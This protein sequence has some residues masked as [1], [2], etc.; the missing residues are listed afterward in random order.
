MERQTLVQR[1]ALP[2]DEIEPLSMARL[3]VRLEGLDGLGAAERELVLRLVYAVGD[4]AIAA[5]VRI[6]PEAITAAV[7]ALQDGRPVVTDVKMVRAG[8]DRRRAAR[9]GCRVAC[10]ID[11]PEVAER[12]RLSNLPR[13]VEAMR[14]LAPA[15]DGGVVAVGNA[16]TAL[17]AVLDLVDA[18]IARPA[19]I[20]GM[21]VGF[22]AAAEA[23][24]EL[25][26]R[27]VPYITVE[28][29]RGG[30]PL[31]VSAVNTLLRRA[32]AGSETGDGRTAIMFLG[33]GSRARSAAEAMEAIVT[34]AQRRAGFAT[35]HWGYLEFAQPTIA[36]GL[37]RCVADGATRVVC[38]PYFL[39][40]GMHMVRDLPRVLREEQQKYPGVEIVMGRHIGLHGDL[41]EVLLDRIAESW[42]LP[43]VEQV[44]INSA[45]YN[46]PVT[47]PLDD[48]DE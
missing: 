15:I 9:L 8:I 32:A 44:E 38:I 17:L 36:E 46:A 48:D 11:A 21:P 42:W 43:P 34:A 5:A 33:H 25:M 26:A 12:A 19:A 35:V 30:T 16:P 20:V 31:A 41:I 13:A 18:G 37:A 7:R 24:T 40:V 3:G 22:V 45:Y 14:L 29:T 39:H 2:P 1:Y 4:P 10:A 23:K 28:G 47:G 27:D 6:H